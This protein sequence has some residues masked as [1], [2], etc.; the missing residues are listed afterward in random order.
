MGLK[1]DLLGRAK[2]RRDRERVEVTALVAARWGDL[3]KDRRLFVQRMTAHDFSAYEESRFPAVVD[4]EGRVRRR[5][6]FGNI[7]ARLLV[8]CLADE[9]GV[10]VFADADADALGE[11]D[12][13]LLERLA[14]EAMRVNGML[15][16]EETSLKNAPSGEPSTGSPGD[17]GGPSPSCSTASTPPS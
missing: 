5:V 2:D 14:H 15:R 11:E 13:D 6:D 17:S 12:K 1:E 4:G 9:A 3:L 7:N 8:R 16:G 10:R